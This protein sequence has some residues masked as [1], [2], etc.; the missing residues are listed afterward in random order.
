MCAFSFDDNSPSLASCSQLPW[1]YRRYVCYPGRR[2]CFVWSHLGWSC[3]SFDG[4]HCYSFL[5]IYFSRDIFK[6]SSFFTCIH[7]QGNCQAFV[8]EIQMAKRKHRALQQRSK[9]LHLEC[10]NNDNL[11]C[12]LTGVKKKKKTFTVFFIT[13]LF[14]DQTL[15]KL[16]KI[17]YTIR[18]T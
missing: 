11:N 17:I 15:W 12:L 18:K 2:R 5:E 14:L 10:I 7:F 1:H 13:F 6:S 9:L 4:K 3:W 8:M 16:H